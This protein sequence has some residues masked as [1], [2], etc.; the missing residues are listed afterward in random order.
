MCPSTREEDMTIELTPKIE[1][2]VQRKLSEGSYTDANE[3]IEAALQA[4]QANEERNLKLKALI[5]EGLADS[6][7]GRFTEYESA[8]NLKQL[9]SQMPH[10]RSQG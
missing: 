7:A 5:A 2:L 10:R 9:F 6:E 1:E 3:L 8:D 4:L